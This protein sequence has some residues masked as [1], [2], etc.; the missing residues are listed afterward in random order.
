ME[1]GKSGVA[2]G[3]EQRWLCHL[4]MLNAKPPRLVNP[5]PEQAS[6]L[7]TCATLLISHLVHLQLSKEL[8]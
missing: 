4:G 3:M 7:H 6:E 5:K 8:R 1:A 2:G